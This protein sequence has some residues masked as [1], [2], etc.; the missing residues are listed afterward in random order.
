MVTCIGLL[1]TNKSNMTINL[2]NIKLNSKIV[3]LGLAT[4]LFYACGDPAAKEG[5]NGDDFPPDADTFNATALTVSASGGKS[6]PLVPSFAAGSPQ[7]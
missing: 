1:R 4:S 2:K 7:A 5:T 3:V 6:S